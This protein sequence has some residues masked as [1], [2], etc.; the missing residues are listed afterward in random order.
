MAHAHAG[1]DAGADHML[2]DD[3]QAR[4]IPV[5]PVRT[6]EDKG[7]PL[8]LEVIHKSVGKGVAVVVQ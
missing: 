7:D 4:C 1:Q 8:L 6:A 2:C 5:Q 3:G